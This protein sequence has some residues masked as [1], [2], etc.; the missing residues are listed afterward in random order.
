M[1]GRTCCT[2]SPDLLPY[3]CTTVTTHNGKSRLP[4]W[5]NPRKSLPYKEVDKDKD[6]ITENSGYTPG[7]NISPTSFTPVMLLSPAST[8]K[9]C[10]VDYNRKESDDD[11]NGPD[12]ILESMMWGL[13]PPWH[14]SISPKGHGLTTNN[15]RIENIK[16]SKLYR[17]ALESN[18]RCVVVCDGFYEWKTFTDK[19]KQPYLIYA[20][21]NCIKCK[22][23]SKD[24]ATDKHSCCLK[25]QKL[26][27]MSDNWKE[28]YGWI[29]Q[30]PLFMAGIYSEWNPTK[31]NLH[32]SS[33]SNAVY[34]YTIITRESGDTLK[35]IHHRM[36]LFLANSQ[37]VNLWLNPNISSYD[38]IDI[39]HQRQNEDELSW[40]P[41]SPSVGSVKNQ[42]TELMEKVGL[43]SD[44][45]AINKSTSKSS[46]LMMSWLKQKS[47]T[48]GDGTNASTNS[49]PAVVNNEYSSTLCKKPKY[50]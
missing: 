4:K 26:E 2:L 41:V 44:G 7:V 17:P 35:W 39:L 50:E 49:N 24:Q 27:T 3:A 43:N 38:A 1:C 28:D 36:P 12:L 18:K 45:K 5:N 25:S 20:K 42:G 46:N 23:G 40:H 30:K 11:T 14:R 16:E 22:E 32:E 10:S 8:N 31:S 37:D 29:G 34:S 6:Y 19:T 33:L 13:I 48:G 47:K 21:Q 15:A 9:K